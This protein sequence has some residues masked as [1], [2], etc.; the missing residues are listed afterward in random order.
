MIVFVDS[1]FWYALAVRRDPRHSQAAAFFADFDA[2]LCTTTFVFSEVASLLT[3]RAGKSAAIR[4]CEQIRVSESC[5]IVH[6]TKEDLEAAWRLFVQ[7]RELDFDL[8]DAVSFTVMER[9]E[10][11]SALCFDR[12]FNQMGF[13]V[14][15]G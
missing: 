2:S 13:E 4:L 3:K 10:L 7:R 14:L 8:V 6:P 5:E 15:P 1:S 9:L 12:H 11:P